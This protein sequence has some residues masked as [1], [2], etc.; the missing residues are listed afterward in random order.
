[1]KTTLF[2]YKGYLRNLPSIKWFPILRE[3][4]MNELQKP[5][6]RIRKAGS[7]KS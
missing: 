3:G 7:G 1:M 6:Q 5:I 2:K 4:F